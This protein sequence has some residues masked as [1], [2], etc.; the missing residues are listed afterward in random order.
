MKRIAAILSLFVISF[1]TI[2]FG[3]DVPKEE[4]VEYLN[5][6]E[7]KESAG[8][9]RAS[10]HEKLPRLLIIEVNK[11]WFELSVDERIENAKKWYSIW[12]HSVPDGVV[13]ILGAEKG[14]PVVFYRPDGRIDLAK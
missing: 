4:V 5:S 12:R 7:V 14:V 3:H 13:S 11:H 10:M 2:A 1:S 9:E 6:K 8:I